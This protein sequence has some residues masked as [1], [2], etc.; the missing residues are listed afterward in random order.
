MHYLTADSKLSQK[1]W[2][3]LSIFY[4]S[5]GGNL[6]TDSPRGGSSQYVKGDDFSNIW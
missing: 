3:A 2:Y 4:V 1:S 6:S 5:G